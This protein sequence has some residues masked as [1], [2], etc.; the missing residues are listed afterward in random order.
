MTSKKLR[1]ALA[2]FAGA[3]VVAALGASAFAGP[4]KEI[5]NDCVNANVALLGDSSA[6]DRINHFIQDKPGL[7]D[8]QVVSWSVTIPTNG[9]TTVYGVKCKSGLAC[10]NFAHAFA[11]A[12]ADSSPAAWC[13]DS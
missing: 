3:S 7:P 9:V 13:G 11:D 5:N 4:V 12:N 1:F 8:V 6:P 10:N 2:A